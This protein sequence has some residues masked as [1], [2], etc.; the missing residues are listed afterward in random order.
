MIQI[1]NAAEIEKMR[2]AGHAVAR[3]LSILEKSIVPGISTGVLNAIAEEE[4]RLMGAIPVF[5]NYPHHHGGRPFPGAICASVNDEVVHGLPGTRVL[6]DGD[7]ISIDFGVI[8]DGYAG[9]SAI[10]AAVGEVD[11]R[12]LKLIQITEESLMKGI[13]QAQAGNKL[14]AV[15]H[16]IQKHAEVNG[17][18]VVREYVGHG[19]GKEMHEEPAVPNYGSPHRGPLLQEGMA[20]A[21]EPM[22]N[23]GSPYVYTLADQWTVRTRDGLPSAH[24]EHSIAITS[25][26]P[27]ILTLR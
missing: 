20:L 3:V 22:L 14:G 9:D 16:A 12:V 21:I 6:Q 25:Q 15:S 4:T 17:F 24:F 26:G 7:I 13:E 2:K 27:E 1:K 19:I 23:L 10:T 11:P 5:K 8:L 18:S